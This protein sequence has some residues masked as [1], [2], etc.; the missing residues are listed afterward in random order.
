MLRARYRLCRPTSKFNCRLDST[1]L[2]SDSLHI[3]QPDS[4]RIHRQQQNHKLTLGVSLDPLTT[5]LS[6]AEAMPPKY[7][8]VVISDDDDVIVEAVV[9]AV[10][11]KEDEAF[12][13]SL[14]VGI[15]QRVPL[16]SL[17]QACFKSTLVDN[18]LLGSLLQANSIIISTFGIG[19][20]LMTFT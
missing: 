14:Q 20:E 18:T 19:T 11:L 7:D 12:A 6:T 3:D 4:N 8:E 13:R 15:T 2:L 10:Q 9:R 17:K 1:S 5:L 16:I